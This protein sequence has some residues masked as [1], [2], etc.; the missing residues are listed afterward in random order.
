MKKIICLM[1]AII[2]I[3]GSVSASVYSFAAP[4]LVVDAKAKDNYYN[5]WWDY[6]SGATKFYVYVDG[7]LDGTKK[8][9]SS[10][11]YTFTTDP[12]TAGI[13]HTIQLKA[14]KNGKIIAESAKIGRYLAPLIP[15]LTYKSDSSSYTITGSVSSG[16]VHGY[17]LYKLN[18]KTNKYVFYK[19]IEK[20]ITVKTNGSVNKDTYKAKAYVTYN[21]KS[22]YS[23]FCAPISCNPSLSA[24]TLSSAKSNDVGKITLTWKAPDYTDFTG[25]Q[26]IYSSYDSFGTFRMKAAEKNKTSMTLSLVPGICYKIGVRTYRN[27]DGGKIYGKWSNIKTLYTQAK[28]PAKVNVKDLLNNKVK[29]S[30]PGAT[31]NEK[32]NKVLDKIL[33]KIGCGT[34]ST[35][36]TY[37][38]VRFAYRY[39]ATSQFKKDGDFGVSGKKSSDYTENAVLKMIENK[40]KTGSCYEYNYLFHYLCLRMGL[41][42]TYVVDGMVSSGSGRTGHWWAMMKIAGNNYYYDPRMQLYVGGTTGL[43]FFNLPMNGDNKYSD[44]YRFYDAQAELK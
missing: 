38:K 18:T 6:D 36:K 1:L 22:Y 3:F 44:Y 23:Q 20:S 37:D 19:N 33:A 10:K 12:Y 13:K 17:A 35:Y 24:V 7:K 4:A 27:V 34:D 11:S 42:N 9:N 26:I 29:V 21:N 31:G 5:V 15:K 30:K 25:Y 16:T 39:V 40:G 43:N 32:L 2:T 14:E 41:K 28:V 8:A